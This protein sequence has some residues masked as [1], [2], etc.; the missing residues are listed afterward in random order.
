PSASPNV[1]V[2]AAVL[3]AERAPILAVQ[4]DGQRGDRGEQSDDEGDDRADAPRLEV[5][6]HDGSQAD[7][8][9]EER[10]RLVYRFGKA[11]RVDLRRDVNPAAAHRNGDL[12]YIVM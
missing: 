6:D 10:Q 5:R 3:A 8:H 1:E 9:V 7:P 12:T 2:V 11:H 4:K